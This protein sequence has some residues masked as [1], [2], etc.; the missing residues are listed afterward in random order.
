M[1][2]LKLKPA[3]ETNKINQTK[4]IKTY[5]YRVI[6]LCNLNAED[7]MVKHIDF[8]EIYLPRGMKKLFTLGIFWS[9]NFFYFKG[10]PITNT[11]IFLKYNLKYQNIQKETI[12]FNFDFLWLFV[13]LH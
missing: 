12:F 3:K 9:E 2:L 7:N 10:A 11:K 1:T 5:K 6:F 8:E 13:P 4:R